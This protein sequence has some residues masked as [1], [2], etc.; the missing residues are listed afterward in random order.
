MNACSIPTT[1][2]LTFADLFPVK[3]IPSCTAPCYPT[4]CDDCPCPGEE[5]EPC[6]GSEIN[7]VCDDCDSK[8]ACESHD[9]RAGCETEALVVKKPGKKP[10]K[11]IGKKQAAVKDPTDPR[12]TP[13][14]CPKGQKEKGCISC[15]F[16]NWC[17][18]S[19]D[20]EE[21]RLF[22]SFGAGCCGF[23]E[24]KM[25]CRNPEGIDCTLEKRKEYRCPIRHVG[26]PEADPSWEEMKKRQKDGLNPRTG[27]KQKIKDNEVNPRHFCGTDCPV[28]HC[29]AQY[30]YAGCKQA[31]EAIDEALPTKEQLPEELPRHCIA[32]HVGKYCETHVWVPTGPDSCVG[33]A[34]EAFHR[35]YPKGKSQYSPRPEEHCDT[36][37]FPQVRKP[38][39]DTCPHYDDV[40]KEHECVFRH[41]RPKKSDLISEEDTVRL[42]TTLH[43]CDHWKSKPD[44]RCIGCESSGDCLTHD[45]EKQDC[46]AKAIVKPIA[47]KSTSK[48]KPRC[49]P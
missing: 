28:E 14:T 19:G 2:Q 37:K 4:V 31:V 40:K 1:R 34:L 6:T 3:E 11:T 23:S 24:A 35:R 18:D 29:T 20:S 7:G 46:V 49:S 9:P 21:R 48:K 41:K 8:T 13:S 44:P 25:L 12:P 22:Q 39:K 26:E 45:P 5:L 32:C 10:A 42:M 30:S 27:L 17:P 16:Y 33:K 43:S 15:K 38:L 47:K 36:C